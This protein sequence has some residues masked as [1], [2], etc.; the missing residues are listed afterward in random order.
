MV[1]G[2]HYLHSLGVVHRDLKLDN[3]LLSVKGPEATVKIADFGLSALVRLGSD[4][5]VGGNT[6]GDSEKRKRYKG[7]VDM[8]G[9]KE[10]FAPEMIDQAYGPQA[11]VWA[12][13]C[14]LYELLCGHYAFPNYKSR[15]QQ[16]GDADLYGRIHAVKYKTD[17]Y[18]LPSRTPEVMDLMSKMLVRDPVAR[19]RY[20]LYYYYYYY[21]CSLVMAVLTHRPVTVSPISLMN[22]QCL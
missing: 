13:G 22:T 16:Q 3:I 21:Y 9:T 7:L 18:D 5:Y 11:D 10:Y 20:E 4:G 17:Q 12:L 6:Q 8:W 15:S 19:Y 14:I 1:S 2:V